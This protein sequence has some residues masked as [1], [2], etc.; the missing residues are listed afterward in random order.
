MNV[1]NPDVKIRYIKTK[2][3]TRK[4]TAYIS[5]DCNLRSSHEKINTFLKENFIP[6]IFTKAYVEG[7]SIYYNA[8]PHLYNDYFIMMDIK[9][10]FPNISHK[11]LEKKLYYEINLKNKDQ[12][13]PIECREIIELCSIGKKGLPLGFVTSPILSNIYLKE[14]DGVF[15]GKLK[16]LQL[17]NV[18]YTRYADDIVVSFKLDTT[19]NVENLSNFII[20]MT[21]QILS[22]YSLRLNPN[23]TR[24]YNLNVSNHVKITGINITKKDDQ[25]RILTVGRSVKNK[26]YWD[27]LGL[28]ESENKN[29][30]QINHIKGLQSFV[31]SVEKN[32]YEDCYSKHM[33]EKV[34]R[35][36]FNNI[37]ELIDSL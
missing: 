7:S 28:Y 17:N 36:G 37:K 22:R 21:Q 33:I 8:L 34:Q 6:S 18:I 4:I 24:T 13:S 9:S 30:E 3:K 2:N 15:Y 10:F 5:D 14:F 31:L 16:Q 26:L 20:D 19:T 32:G 35:H 27:A 11:K 29:Q 1:N 23:K 25:K 12:I